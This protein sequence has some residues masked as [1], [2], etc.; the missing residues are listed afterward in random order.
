M[1]INNPNI[2]LPPSLIPYKDE[3][4]NFYKNPPP[5]FTQAQY[6]PTNYLLN[7][8]GQKIKHG[9]WDCDEFNNFPSNLEI[10]NKLKK[11][12]YNYVNKNLREIKFRIKNSSFE[13]FN[14]SLS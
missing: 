8:I 9:N 5:N 11:T 1:K 4:D 10:K 7:F 13:E 3:I 6:N 2:P 14:F 12:I